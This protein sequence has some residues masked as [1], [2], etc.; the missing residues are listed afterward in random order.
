[1]KHPGLWAAALIVVLAGGATLWR[2]SQSG[3]PAPAATPAAPGPSAEVRERLARGV[4]LSGWL[5][6]GP[7]VAQ[8]APDAADWQRL[9]ALGLRHARILVDPAAFLNDRGLPDP[10]ALA[11]LREAIGAAVDQD[12]LVV[13]ALQLPSGMKAVLDAAPV[14]AALGG[15]WRALALSVRDFPPQRLALE[16]LNEPEIEDAEGWRE[17]AGWL[18]GTL[19]EVAPA[20]TLVVSGHRY[21]A[22]DDLLALR[23]LADRNVVYAFHFYEPHA[24]THQGADWG[25]PVWRELRRVPYPSSPGR[26]AALLP[27]LGGEAREVLRWHGEQRWNADSLATGIGRAAQWG[28]QHGVTVWCSEFGAI[29]GAPREDRLAWLRDT[30]ATL[31]AQGIG[32]SHW[33]YAGGFGIVSGEPGKRV[34]DEAVAEALGLKPSP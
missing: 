12:L 32:W 6:H 3:A 4:N 24:F 18:A 5:Q 2:L 33:D 8:A 29:R 9:R 21:S 31:E 19:R 10:D 16:P 15:I 23:P 34:V 28:R 7:A 13:L 30:R 20:H 14:R 1:M 17:L 11:S 26:V 25:E 22:V 27:G